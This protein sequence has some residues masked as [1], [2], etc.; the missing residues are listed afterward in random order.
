MRKGF[1]VLV[2]ER[3]NM[4]CPTCFNKHLRS[5]KE[6]PIDAYERLCVYLKEDGGISRLK[7]MGGEPTIHSAFDDIVRIGQKYFDSIHIFTNGV[8][9]K[10]VDLSLR[11]K[12]TIIYNLACMGKD[13]PAEK[14]LPE[15]DF[16]H[17]Y[18]VRISADS[19]VLTIEATLKHIYEI[20]GERMNVN[21][22]LD[23]TED[24]FAQ[25]YSIIERWNAV[26]SFLH[27]ELKIVYRV[28]HG[29]PHCFLKDS[30][31]NIK[32]GRSLCSIDCAGLVTSDLKLR[33]CNQTSDNLLDLYRDDKFVPWRIVEQYLLGGN[34]RK[35]Y[36]CLSKGCRDCLVY[37]SECDGGCFVFKNGLIPR[38]IQMVLP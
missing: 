21:L 30:G 17:A 28:D 38:P 20:I 2:T 13:Y 6:M 37:G 15:A 23:C 12:D 4:N 10:I 36:E 26:S 7:I 34:M 27:N 19:D 16:V 22:T 24:I 31:I 1:R 29:I 5:G 35:K 11:K 8:D 9:G 32:S 14:L 3:C 33:H 25:R 18:E